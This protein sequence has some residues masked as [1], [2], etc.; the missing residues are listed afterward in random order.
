MSSDGQAKITNFDVQWKAVLQDQQ[1]VWLDITVKVSARMNI[2]N[3]KKE[4]S[5]NRG[6]NRL[7]IVSLLRDGVNKISKLLNNVFEHL[8]TWA[9]LL[10]QVR[11]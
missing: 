10:L 6:R 9:Y 8:L 5:C 4:L 7:W 3:S 1:V 11:V 2:L